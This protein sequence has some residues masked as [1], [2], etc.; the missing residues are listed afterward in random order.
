MVKFNETDYEDWTNFR[1]AKNKDVISPKEF[2]LVCYLHARYFKHTYYKPCTCSPTTIN[3]WI[4][5]LNLLWTYTR[6]WE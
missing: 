1:N 5:D 2:E 3:K 4:K 6:E